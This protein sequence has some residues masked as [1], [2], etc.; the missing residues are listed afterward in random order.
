MG[1]ARTLSITL[2]NQASCNLFIEL[3]M[4]ASE[5]STE[6]GQS[7]D[8]VN[9][10]LSECF[11]F[12]HKRGIVNGKSKMKVNITFKPS[13]RFQFETTLVCVA[14]EKMPKDLQAQVKQSR[15]LKTNAPKGMEEKA[16]IQIKCK[17]DYPLLRFTDVRN[18]HVSIANLWE[19]FEMTKMNKELLQPLNQAEFFFNN[20]D[21][22]N[23]SNEELMAG[24]RQFSWDFGKVPI[25]NGS[26]PRKIILT[27]K[28]VGGV[29][30]DFRFKLPNDNEIEMEAW[31]DPGEPTAEQAFEKHILSKRIFTIEPRVGSLAPGEQTDCA[32][33]YYP[34]EVLKH[35]LNVFFQI[36]NGKPLLLRFEGETLQRRAQLQMLKHTY[37][38]PPV[39]IGLEWPIT[40]PIEIKN[41]G[42]TKLK[43]QIDTAALEDLNEGNFDFKIFEIQNPEGTLSAGDTQY[44]YTLFRPL[45]AK[46]Y[47][48]DLPIKISDIEGP[49]PH[50]HVL[51]LR[52]KGYHPE[53]AQL[54]VEVPF[55]EDLP[56]CRAYVG[57]EGQ[58]AAFSYESIDFGDLEHGQVANRFVILYN[59]N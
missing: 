41:L 32:V 27:I 8:D 56:K 22:T 33:F 52:G 19:R 51:K 42:I 44:I 16:S 36:T 18:D 54:P 43:Y 38:L 57:E 12:D 58:M 28:N 59:L 24:L 40:Y 9:K 45:E 26:K 5:S 20:S 46:E 50:S 29:P 30:A 55:Y 37:V 2:T 53:E 23:A 34:K 39:P 15:S 6:A 10:I 47:A 49:S 17:G 25:R 11:R 31:A 35:H 1:E 48:V 3:Q 21:K 13:C 4:Q 7:A 14:R